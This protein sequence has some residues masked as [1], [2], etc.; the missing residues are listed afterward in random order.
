[1]HTGTLQLALYVCLW[2]TTTR[3]TYAS[4]PSHKYIFLVPILLFFSSTTKFFS[5]SQAPQRSMVSWDDLPSSSGDDSVT[6][7][8][9][10]TIF[11]EEWRG[12]AIDLPSFTCQHGTLCE[13]VVAF[14][15][16]D[17]GRRFLTCAQKEVPSCNY[18]EWVDPE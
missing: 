18:V 7:K 10:A 15:S 2:S 1:M 6:S 11:C 12:L 3:S 14:E 17:T 16:V 4:S 13:K 9:P 8:A 5:S